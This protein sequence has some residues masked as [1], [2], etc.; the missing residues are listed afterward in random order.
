MMVRAP[1]REATG[2]ALARRPDEMA[3]NPELQRY[4]W[5]LEELR[6]SFFAQS[7][8]TSLPV[9]EKRLAQQWQAVEQWRLEQPR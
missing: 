1:G 8:G 7:L 6:V 3:R 9:S 5:M 4:R 2:D